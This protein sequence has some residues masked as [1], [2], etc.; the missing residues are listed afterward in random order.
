MEYKGKS[1]PISYTAKTKTADYTITISDKNFGS[2]LNKY[3]IYGYVKKQKKLAAT[4]DI[5]NMIPSEIADTTSSGSASKIKLSVIYYDSPLYNF[6]VERMKNIFK[7]FGIADN[8]TFEKMT[9]AEELQG[10]LFAGDYDI[11]VSVVDM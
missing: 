8:F 3:M 7:Q 10:R 6:I 11:L 2:G 1:V 5:Y 4:I 9:T